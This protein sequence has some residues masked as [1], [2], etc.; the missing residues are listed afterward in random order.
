MLSIS[1]ISRRAGDF[2]TP[3]VVIAAQKTGRTIGS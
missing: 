1:N 2:H 3:K